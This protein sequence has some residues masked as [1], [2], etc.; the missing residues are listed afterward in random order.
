M[1]VMKVVEDS[2]TK[3]YKI[4]LREIEEP[5]LYWKTSIAHWKWS[6]LFKSTYGVNVIPIN[7]QQDFENIILKS[8]PNYILR[9]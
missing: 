1:S 2:H 8:W 6:A 9:Y 5:W 7:P 3:Y 4:L